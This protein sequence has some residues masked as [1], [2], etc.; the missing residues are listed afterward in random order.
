MNQKNGAKINIRGAELYRDFIHVD[1]VVDE[2]L[3]WT[4]RTNSGIFDVGTGT[5]LMTM[6][7]VNIYMEVAQKKFDISVSD[8]FD[9]EPKHMVSS[10][11]IPHVDFR[12]ALIKTIYE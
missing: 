1:C 7:V 4:N 10:R 3:E 8:P 9:Y 6:D 12:T 2:I 5:A 11:A